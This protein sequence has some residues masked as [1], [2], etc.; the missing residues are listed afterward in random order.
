MAAR[1][2]TRSLE[3]TSCRARERRAL[4]ARATQ[5]PSA[6]LVVSDVTVV[7]PERAYVRILRKFL[8]RGETQ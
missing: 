6:G 8:G 1:S 7:S 3:D 4:V 2:R 5:A